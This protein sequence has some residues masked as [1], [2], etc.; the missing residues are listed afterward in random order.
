MELDTLTLPPVVAQVLAWVA[1]VGAV[2]SVAS[3]VVS[4]IVSG[5]AAKK[6]GNPKWLLGLEV[7]LAVL[8]LNLGRR[9]PPPPAAP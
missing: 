9:R 6:L 3:S 2:L 8:A 7:T 5:R 1:V 4:Q